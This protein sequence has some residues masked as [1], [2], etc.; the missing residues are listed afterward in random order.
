MHRIVPGGRTTATRKVGSSV[1]V[2]YRGSGATVIDGQRVEWEQGDMFVTPSWALVDHEVNEP[3]DLFAISDAPIL[4]ALN[5][6]REAAADG[7]QEVTSIFA[8]A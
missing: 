8:G 5:L 3:S 4:R 6:Y 2:V 7:L 1:F